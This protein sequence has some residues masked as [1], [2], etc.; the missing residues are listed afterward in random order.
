MNFHPADLIEANTF[1]RQVSICPD[2][3]DLWQKSGLVHV[4]PDGVA[5]SFQWS[6]TELQVAVATVRHDYQLWLNH[7][8]RLGHRR[9]LIVEDDVDLRHLYQS[10]L[11]EMRDSDWVTCASDGAEALVNIGAVKPD[12]II[13]DLKM[14]GM[15]G[16]H[17]LDVLAHARHLQACVKVVITGLSKQDLDARYP[18]PDSV[19]LLTKP[20]GFDLL[21]AVVNNTALG[22]FDRGIPT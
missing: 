12:I 16:F 4:T 21:K 3:L 17:M 1:M 7:R 11:E 15:D 5:T 9:I 20:V 14:P 8:S 18:L 19:T 6:V 13:C 10:Q 2:T 22:Q